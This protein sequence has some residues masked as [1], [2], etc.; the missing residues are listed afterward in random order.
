MP[1]APAEPAAVAAGEG[2]PE[3]IVAPGT[4][5]VVSTPIGNL[6]DVT[7]RALAVL[8]EADRIAAEDTRRTRTLLERHGVKVRIIEPYHAHNE[9]RVAAR[10]ADRL[11]RGESIALVTDAGTPGVSDPAYRLVRAALDAGAPVVAVPGPS[12]V[13]CALVA[14]GLPT[15]RFLFQGFPP[16]KPGPRRRLLAELAELPH[17]LVFFEAAPRLLGFLA[18]VVLVLGDREIAVARE[19][20]KRFEDIWR[21]PVAAY[22]EARVG[23]PEVRGEV[24][25]IVAGR[26]RPAPGRK[27]RD[28]AVEGRLTREG[29]LADGRQET[30]DRREEAGRRE[31]AGRRPGGSRRRIASP[32][33]G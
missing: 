2:A 12:A 6:A 1:R 28:Q 25:V 15:D 32:G 21:G 33:G 10:L 7:L 24:T 16:R 17:T 14:S 9:A 3:R 13:L 4:L 30:D 5:Y 19:L 27:G 8:A 23:A 20:T 22:R 18:D 11:R 31:P 26:P 29:P